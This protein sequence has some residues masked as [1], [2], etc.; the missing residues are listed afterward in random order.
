MGVEERLRD[1]R[2]AAGLSQADVA[3]RMDVSR[4]AV[5]RWETGMAAPSAENLIEL[6]R[7]YGVTL[8]ELV[9]GAAAP[10]EEEE[11]PAPE[12]AALEPSAGAKSK[13]G[14]RM[15]VWLAALLCLLALVTG[16][17][18]GYIAAPKPE[19][20]FLDMADMKGEVVE[21][22]PGLNIVAGGIVSDEW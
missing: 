5:S 1:L 13:Q 8:D 3:E 15:A 9:Y 17:I 19:K 14:R 7:L 20:E 18:I 11:P 4:Q 2:Q 21:G 22:I 6:S 16:L 12:P 10:A